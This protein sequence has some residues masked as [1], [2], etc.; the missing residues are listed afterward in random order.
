MGDLEVISL[1]NNFLKSL[2]LDNKIELKINSLGDADSRLN[3]R[4][5]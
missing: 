4:K 5:F 2:N 1:A 3:Y